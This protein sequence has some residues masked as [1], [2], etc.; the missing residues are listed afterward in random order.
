MRVSYIILS[1]DV[2][3][4]V[5]VSLVGTPLTHERYNRRHRV[6]HELYEQEFLIGS[7]H[8]HCFI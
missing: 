2:R 7:V 3:N 4:R 8:L 5:V 6:R 1:L